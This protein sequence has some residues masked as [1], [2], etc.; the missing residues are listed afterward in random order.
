LLAMLAYKTANDGGTA[1]TA[2]CVTLAIA[3]ISA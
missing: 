2:E 3:V 1:N